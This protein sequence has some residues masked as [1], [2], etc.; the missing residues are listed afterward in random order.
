MYNLAQNLKL[1]LLYFVGKIPIIIINFI[2]YLFTINLLTYII[3]TILINVQFEYS[4]Y[5]L[6]LFSK[7]IGYI[8]LIYL[9]IITIIIGY[10]VLYNIF[11]FIIHLGKKFNFRQPFIYYTAT[12]VVLV[13]ILF[14]YAVLYI[15]FD[16]C[17]E[18][19]IEVIERL[20]QFA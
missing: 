19:L 18:N 3:G 7:I 4:Y 10:G 2:L 9:I 1:R 16:F 14:C 5:I 15:F 11:H 8:C 12:I 13:I 20:W 6:E 17:F